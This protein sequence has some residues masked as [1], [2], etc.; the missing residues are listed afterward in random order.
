MHD[1][2]LAN[3]DEIFGVPPQMKLNP[4]FSPREAGFHREAISSTEGG[5]IPSVGTDLAEK[6]HPLTRMA[7][8]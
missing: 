8:F 6:S 2:I 1:E 4:S 7:F 5:F 3:S